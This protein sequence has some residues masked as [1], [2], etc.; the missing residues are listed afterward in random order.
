MITE[1][2][3]GSRL[4]TKEEVRSKI[5]VSIGTFNETLRLVRARGLLD[6]KPGPGGGLFAAEQSPIVRLGNAVLSLDIDRESVTQAVRIRNVLEHLLVEDAIDF[7]S[8]QDLSMMRAALGRM[9]NAVLS[10]DGIGFLHANWELHT[11]IAA[12]SPNRI[13]HSIY[14]NLLDLVEEHTIAVF[15]AGPTSLRE[16][17]TERYMLHAALIEAIAGGDRPRARQLLDDHN[18]GIRS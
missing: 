16:F 14:I 8:S 17:H 12:A 1:V 2:K 5:G 13:L 15:A 11:C 9:S 18:R 6:V 7:A 10:D 3:P 4:G